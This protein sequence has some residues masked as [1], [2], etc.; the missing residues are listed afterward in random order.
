MD[1]PRLDCVGWAA[2][3]PAVI[4]HHVG[5]SVRPHCVGHRVDLGKQCGLVQTAGLVPAPGSAYATRPLKL[6]LGRASK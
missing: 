2:H 6:P 4:V 5:P 1:T 3:L